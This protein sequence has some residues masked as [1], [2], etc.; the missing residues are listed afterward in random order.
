MSIFE[1][2]SFNSSYIFFDSFL[3]DCLETD[4]GFFSD[5]NY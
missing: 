3:V 4:F 1:S 2:W 5:F